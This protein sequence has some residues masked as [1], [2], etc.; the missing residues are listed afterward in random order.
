M[1]LPT[2]TSFTKAGSWDAE[3]RV[4]TAMKSM[5]NFTMNG[6]DALQYRSD[7]LYSDWYAD[8]HTL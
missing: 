1:S 7:S 8:D 5:G 4:H 6:I 2:T 3:T